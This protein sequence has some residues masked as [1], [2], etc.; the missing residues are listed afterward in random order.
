MSGEAKAAR[1]TS[2][3]G[4]QC[5][6]GAY[7]KEGE[8]PFIQAGRDRTRGNGCKI[9]EERFLSDIRRNSLLRGW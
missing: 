4:T 9:K 6:L 5:I 8:Q 2:I 3:A 7:K 1:I